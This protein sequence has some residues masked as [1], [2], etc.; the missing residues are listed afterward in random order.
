VVGINPPKNPALSQ[1]RKGV[2]VKKLLGLACVIMM[3]TTIA[4]T[5][6][7]PT[8]KADL[9]LRHGRI[10]TIDTARSWAESVAIK[11]GRITYVGV[12]AGAEPWVGTKTKVVDLQGRFVMPSFIDAH[13]HPISSG[14][15]INR[16]DLSDKDSK[17]EVLAAIKTYAE[18]HPKLPWILGNGWAYPIFPNANPMKEWLDEIVPDRPVLLDSYDEHSAWANSKALEMLGIT[19]DMPDPPNGRIERNEKGEPTGTLRES[20]ADYAFDKAPKASLKEEIEGLR[21]ALAQ[22]KENGITGFQD[23][24]VSGL[25]GKRL[26]TDELIVYRDAE[27]RGALTARVSTAIYADPFG[28][29]GAWSVSDPKAKPNLNK[30]LKQLEG[31]KQTRQKYHSRL[32]EA[33][34]VKIF[35]DGVAESQTAAM[36]HPYLNK[37]GVS[38]TANWEPDLLNP[39]VAALDKENFQ[40]HFHAI[41]DRA[42]RYSL[43]AIEYALKQNGGRDR[44]PLIA[45][46][47]FIDPADVPRFAPLGVVPVFQALWAYEDSYVHDLTLPYITPET[48]RW[49]YPM[50]SVAST[51]A[52]MAMGSDWSVSSMNPLEAIEVAMTRQNPEGPTASDKPFYPE[53]RIDLRTGL[54]AY[55]IGSAYACFW[56]KETG[57][58][59]TGKSG[60][61][62]VLSKNPFTVPATELSE[63]KVLM[64][65]FQGKAIYNAEK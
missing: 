24:D 39:F 23:A 63:I 13:T 2:N 16:C 45:H 17:E 1:K 22:M 36:L 60:D 18:A 51:G 28:V 47:Q 4:S 64:T 12:D 56:E 35:E 31:F 21:L 3:V 34:T 32:I 61:L 33:S 19:K 58:I 55:T 57:S 42:V 20:A 50:G 14:T 29:E 44:R 11:D 27:Q 9:V 54:A 52:T 26:A 38:G 37:N 40:V 15:E 41:G 25:D 7:N 65:L 48:A 10:Y 6:E 30:T 5:P 43:D 49:M 8:P 62:V 59:E 53:E 46:L